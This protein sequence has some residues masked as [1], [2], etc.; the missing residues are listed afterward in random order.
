MSKSEDLK[1]LREWASHTIR[2]DPYHR[3]F[4]W[5]FER[6]R[7]RKK[8]CPGCLRE[9]N[10]TLKHFH[11]NVKTVELKSGWKMYV[12]W[13]TRCRSCHKDHNKKW[14]EKTGWKWK[15]RTEAQRR[16]RARNLEYVRMRDRV[17]KRKKD[18]KRKRRIAKLKTR[19]LRLSI[20]ATKEMIRVKYFLSGSSENQNAK[21]RAWKTFV[22]R[23]H[24]FRG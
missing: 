24:F 16:Y 11:T 12:T 7:V 5:F 2:T 9:L 8:T 18:K 20:K 1:L 21:T 22:D 23:N 10:I 15:N 19:V 4:I 6:W 13:S 3:T 14:R 17:H